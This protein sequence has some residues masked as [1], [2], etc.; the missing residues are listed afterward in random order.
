MSARALDLRLIV[1][2]DRAAAAPR[3]VRDVVAACLRAGAPAIQ[4]RDKHAT[5]RELFEQAVSLRE[6]TREHNA[7]LFV[8]DRVD[9]ALAAGADGAHLGPGDLPLP[10]VRRVVPR[11]FVL[12]WSADTVEEAVQA[13]RSGANYIGCGAIFG[14]S[15]KDVGGEEIGVESVRSVVSAVAIPVVGIGGISVENF[16]SVLEVGAAG[17]AVIS[18]VMGARD[19]GG[20][21]REMLMGAGAES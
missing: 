11:E 1:I 14:S 4:L 17:V 3:D 8:N 7:T 18:A 15:S 19:P 9:V 16:R 5:T 21:V 10:A 6:L 13:E 12:G 20:V 2:T